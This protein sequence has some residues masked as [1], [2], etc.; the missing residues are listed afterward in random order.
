MKHT[1][2]SF[3]LILLV[4]A[5]KAQIITLT[6]H[7]VQN[8]NHSSSM[9]TV[10]AR[11]LDLI[12]YPNYT[13]GEN[14]YTFDMDK[15]IVT[16]KNSTGSFFS[17]EI[18]EVNKNENIL[19]CIVFDGVRNILFIVGSNENGEKEFLMEYINDDKVFGHFSLN[20][21]FSYTVE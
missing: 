14:V 9:S 2:F 4:T 5:T 20:S 10:Q 7:T 17:S 18:T 15:K 21:D 13:V 19:D 12:E 1:F 8:F 11:Q 16:F 3:L 6:I